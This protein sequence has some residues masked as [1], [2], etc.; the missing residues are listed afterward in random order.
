MSEVAFVDIVER[1]NENN[2]ERLTIQQ[3]QA[4]DDNDLTAAESIIIG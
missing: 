3:Y 1:F 2:F 4:S